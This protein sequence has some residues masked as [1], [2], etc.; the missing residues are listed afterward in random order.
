MLR[1]FG[2]RTVYINVIKSIHKNIIWGFLN[3][4]HLTIID[5]VDNKYIL[6]IYYVLGMAFT[7]P[8]V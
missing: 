3:N 8:H 4:S 7:I 5:F 2:L 6:F 1:I